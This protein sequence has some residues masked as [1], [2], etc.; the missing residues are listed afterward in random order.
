MSDYRPATEQE[1]QDWANGY[2]TLNAI[3]TE[4]GLMV[5][6]IP[7]RLRDYGLGQM[8]RG[9]VACEQHMKARNSHRGPAVT[10][11]YLADAIHDL[12]QQTEGQDSYTDPIIRDLLESFVALLSTETGGWDGS[13]LDS[14][15]R[16]MADYIGEPLD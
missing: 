2:R 9:T 15:A 4:H 13:T 7:P 14:W 1:A 5:R 8:V 12:A 11:N 10:I 16:E 3:E 6:V